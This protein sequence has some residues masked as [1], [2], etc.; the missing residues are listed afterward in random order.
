MFG[1]NLRGL[2]HI[3]VPVS[4]IDASKAFYHRLGFEEV[5]ARDLPVEGGAIHCAMMER[6][7]LIMELYQLVGADLDAVKQ[8]G[9]GHV[10]HVALDVGDIDAAWHTV[11]DA[12]F[13]PLEPAP[14]F[15]PFWEKGCK[16]FNILGPDGE[17]I[18]F[19]QILT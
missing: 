7:G 6:Q 18:E 1:D 4:N 14:V 15:L 10:D 5:M 8:R 17:R 13:T 19:N 9:H 12:G 16:Y 3:G 2:Q 11:L